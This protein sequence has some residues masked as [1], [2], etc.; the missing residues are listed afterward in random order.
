[1]KLSE[2]IKERYSMKERCSMRIDCAGVAIELEETELEWRKRQ[3]VKGE[4]Y[5][6]CPFCGVWA[7]EQKALSE[8]VQHVATCPWRRAKELEEA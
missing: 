5:Y 2:I 6:E 4:T 3:T 7:L 8:A 1:M